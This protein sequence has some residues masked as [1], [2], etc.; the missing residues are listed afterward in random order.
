MNEQ[1]IEEDLIK[2]EVIIKDSGNN[3]EE[4]GETN[5]DS[6][7]NSGN[8]NQRKP[9]SQKAGLNAIRPDEYIE[10]TFKDLAKDKGKSQ[11]ELFESMF[12]NYI[13]KE[14]EKEMEMA[15]SFKSEI[16]LISN[17]LD[18]IFSH[19]KSI[20][21]KAQNTI[22]AERNNTDQKVENLQKE[23]ETAELKNK[24]LAARNKELETSYEAFTT[25]KQ[26]L[27]QEIEKLSTALNAK[28]NTIETLQR[29][30]EENHITIREYSARI[31][32]LEA[33]LREKELDIRGLRDSLHKQTSIKD[34]EFEKR[35]RL[36][37]DIEHLKS[38]IKEMRENHK[39]EM[40][41][42]EKALLLKY[43]AEKNM[44]VVDIKLQLIDIKN[45]LQEKLLLIN[46]LKE[47]SETQAL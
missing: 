20:T 46:K 38:E 3:S 45:E 4:N 18:N 2:D 47:K 44:A 10:K 16:N 23:L 1:K 41:S 21:E 8:L 30:V 14:Q 6:E 9:K 34:L 28:K 5:S 40:N 33:I 43:E 31:T 35:T 11:T 25:V 19:F 24:E 39:E 13:N 29:D 7:I 32:E 12:W 42:F 26:E 36:E 17:D 27:S 15:L 37:L 22:I